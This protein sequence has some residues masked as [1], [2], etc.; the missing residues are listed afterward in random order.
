MLLFLGVL[1]K[2]EKRIMEALEAG[3]D[4]NVPLSAILERHR[5]IL[6]DMPR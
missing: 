5:E 3:G 2:D 6:R 1:Q 4:M